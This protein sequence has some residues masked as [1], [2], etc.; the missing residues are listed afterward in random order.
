VKT[1]YLLLLTAALLGAAGNNT[2]LIRN[3]TVH[4]VTTPVIQHGSVLVVDGKIAGVGANVH[5]PG[6]ARVVDGRGLQ[7]Y[8]GLINA[9]TNV[10]L[11]E[12]SSLRDT[13]DLDEIGMFNPEL[14]AEIAFNPSSEHVDV[15]RAAGI[16]T[17]ISLPGSGGGGGFGR[18]AAQSVITGQGALMH[19][20]GWTWEEMAVKPSAVMDMD[21]PQIRMV[22]SQY[23]ALIPGG[24]RSYQDEEKQY[25]ERLR[26]LGRF[27]ED[28]RRY[29]K[30]KAERGP[31]FRR[32]IKFEAMI[33]VLEG[34][35]AL[36]V[37]AEKEKAIKDAVAFA[38]KE[39]VKI[40]LADPQEIGTI[41]PLLKAHNIPVVLGKIFE[42]PLHD[43][44]PYDSRY[45]LPN[46]FYKAGVK[47]CFGTFDVEFARNVPFEAAQAAA[48]GLPQEEALK[49]ITINSAEILGVGDRLGS[50]EEG[51]V[52]DL[53]VT[54]GDPLQA[55][56][57]IKEMFIAGK[58]VSL[59]SRHTREYE[60]W[61][62]RP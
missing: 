29:Q 55:K 61:M 59:E 57:H 11:S 18:N 5:A 48:F 26:E 43:D 52:A 39:K 42:L 1:I 53:I 54:D 50:I 44:D 38:D 22:P 12:I 31:D 8:P 23:A 6:G 34:K 16:T 46:E 7:L 45:T 25:Q 47:I 10:G 37:H 62:E 40:I 4:P 19:L 35:Q 36:F 14:R 21:F 27:F 41:G 32:D 30:A 3:V 51:K 2:V 13:V 60:K 56:T 33:P 28:A 20:E 49:A 58:E 15:T 17:V 24:A 9:A